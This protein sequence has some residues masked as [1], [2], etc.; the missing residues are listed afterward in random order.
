MI[1]HLRTMENEEKFHTYPIEKFLSFLKK[2]EQNSIMESRMFIVI[3]LINK[4]AKKQWLFIA[5]QTSQ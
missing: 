2:R 1:S 3:F 4:I 5:I